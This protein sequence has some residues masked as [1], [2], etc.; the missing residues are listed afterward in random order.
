MTALGKYRGI[1]IALAVFLVF[2][3]FVLFANVWMSNQLV[4]ELGP[5]FATLSDSQQASAGAIQQQ[6]KLLQIAAIVMAVVYFI[7]IM[8][9]LIKDVQRRDVEVEA[10]REETD[11]IL[12]TVSEGLFLLDR[13][14][15]IG[16]Q[17]SEALRDMFGMKDDLTGHFFEFISKYVPESTL[18]VAADF[19]E[20]LMG[21]RVKE[22]LIGDLNPLNEVEINLERR[23]GTFEN[24]YLN[25]QFKRVLEEKKVTQLLVSVT[26]V[27][28]EVLLARELEETKEQS[29]AQMDLLVSILHIE[30]SQLSLLLQNTDN[31]LTRINDVLKRQVSS[32]TERQ[33][34]LG[35]IYRET[36]KIKGDA[37]SLNMH[38]F[39]IRAHEFEERIEA[40]RKSP[41][42][43]ANDLLSLTVQLK[44]QFEHLDSVKQMVQRFAKLQLAGVTSEPA[45]DDVSRPA[46][47]APKDPLM[48]LAQKVADR[49]GVHVMLTR[50]G[51]S[52][53]ELPDAYR[54]LISDAAVQLVRNSVAHG[55]ETPEQRSASGKS[56]LGQIAV[57]VSKDDEGGYELIV[58]DDGRGLDLEK[59][60]ARAIEQG[61]L[62]ESAQEIDLRDAIGLL[63]KPGFSTASEADLDAGRGV[64]LDIVGASIKSMRGKVRVGS[65]PGKYCQ[66]RVSLPP[67]SSQPDRIA[68]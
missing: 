51:L 36:H 23:D 57:S 12:G 32:R 9:A 56:P 7:G 25:F 62:D 65:R 22:K 28:R 19:I 55:L 21:D 61:L 39:E 33:E 37:A 38:S 44:S 4:S 46:S 66:F 40:L 43:S 47:N 1:I 34:Q 8:F 3:L 2:L 17:Q 42:L 14:L 16:M 30:P 54:G 6:F 35:E 13:D 68:A 67:V 18:E 52:D 50:M 58:H 59:I 49:R 5:A 15:E 64:G 20:L 45:S 63:F 60:R 24:R 10:A 31:G 48:Q 29:E 41:D 26:D 11:N 53:D 27:T